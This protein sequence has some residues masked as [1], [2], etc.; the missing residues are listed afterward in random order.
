MYYQGA[1]KSY[2]QRSTIQEIHTY[3]DNITNR[4]SGILNEQVPIQIQSVL[5]LNPINNSGRDIKSGYGTEKEILWFVCDGSY[6]Y[7]KNNE[8]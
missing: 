3:N 8:K 6:W 1:W 5:Y 2:I 7:N 4:S